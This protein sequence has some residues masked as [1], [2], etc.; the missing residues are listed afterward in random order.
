MAT[1]YRRMIFASNKKT[2]GWII[3]LILIVTALLV[4]VG[5]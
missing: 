3:V 2:D 5:K 1:K 4:S